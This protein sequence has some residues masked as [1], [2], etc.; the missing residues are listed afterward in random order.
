MKNSFDIAKEIFSGLIAEEI[1]YFMIDN[2]NKV[3]KPENREDLSLG[4]RSIA[5]NYSDVNWASLKNCIKNLQLGEYC[6]ISGKRRWLINNLWITIKKVD[7]HLKPSKLYTDDSNQMK[8]PL[9]ISA[10]DL[11]LD[12]PLVIGYIPDNSRT[13]IK[14]I[15][16][17]KYK[18]DG[19]V[20]WNIKLYDATTD[21]AD[22]ASQKIHKA[23]TKLIKIKT[24]NNNVVDLF[25]K[26]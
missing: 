17:I 6:E 19:S 14:K 5:S 21:V 22:F 18:T 20:D 10:S 25:D 12:F 26:D 2:Y 11:S 1:V 16:V 4:N 13:F 15:H 9:D 23:I 3:N 24:P 8:L 7:E